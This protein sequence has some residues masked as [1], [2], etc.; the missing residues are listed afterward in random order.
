MPADILN[1]I[2]ADRRARLAA[3][4]PSQGVALPLPPLAA[5]LPDS[6][7]ARPEPDRPPAPLSGRF[8]SPGG[9]HRR[10]PPA[11]AFPGPV[12]CEMK[13][14]SPSRGDLAAEAD[15][16]ERA[17]RYRAAGCDSVSVL[18]EEDHFS[19]TLADLI[20]VKQ[21]FPDLAV[22]RKDFL[23]ATEDVH[24]SWRAGADAVLLIAAILSREELAA[25]IAETDRLGMAALVEIHDR[26]ELR[27]I[28]PLQ[29]PLV[30]INSRDL[31]TFRVDLLEPLALAAEIDWPCRLVFES[32][33]FHR[34]D[35]RLARDGGFSAVLVGESVVRDPARVTS[36]VDE[37][38]TAGPAPRATGVHPAPPTDA[39]GFWPWLAARR[40]ARA[41]ASPYRPLVKICGITS[42]ADAMLAVD[43]GADLLGLIYAESPRTAPE[44]LAAEIRAAGVTVPL[45][46]VVLERPATQAR[47]GSAAP[48]G[49][50][51]R[52]D[53]KRGAPRPGATRP[54][55]RSDQRAAASRQFDAG[56]GALIRLARLQGGPLSLHRRGAGTDSH[57][58]HPAFSH[59]R[60]SSRR[61][62]GN[63]SRGT[64]CGAGRRHRR[65]RRA[66]A[67]GVVAR[68]WTQPGHGGGGDSAV[69]PGTDRRL[70][71]PGIKAGN[72]RPGA[73]AA[74][75]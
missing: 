57:P 48:A 39:S 36:L 51:H 54:R 65:D 20:A 50:R 15:P 13:R 32:G 75:L 1:R 67:R 56:G 44:R 10:R 29:P 74:I 46:A 26:D 68:R 2:V 59:R 6:L 7:D 22:L 27:T 23:L 9:A 61:G 38:G 70:Q 11:G 69:A 52:P 21:A 43:L 3:R 31:R 72:K 12:I 5:A 66:A 4:G 8:R 17:G 53:R 28:A 37:M 30:G 55:V 40:T 47:R 64:H 62:R 60:V 18:T 19:G 16:V 42:V 41:T 34:E 33:V 49:D 73:P 63:R 58:A 25:M 71:R 14:R 24:V 35:V 45:V